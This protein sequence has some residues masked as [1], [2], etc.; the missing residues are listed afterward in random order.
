MTAV[1]GLACELT[2]PTGLS[3]E[4]LEALSGAM[5]R[6]EKTVD[7]LEDTDIDF[8]YVPALAPVVSDMIVQARTEAAP[9]AHVLDVNEELAHA[10]TK[11]TGIS[12]GIVANVL[13]AVRAHH[14]AAAAADRAVT[15]AALL[16]DL[17]SDTDDDDDGP[18]T[19]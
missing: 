13:F 16:A 6:Y 18:D 3:L 2:I 1:V 15:V 17:S 11:S 10:V 8:G 12:Y 14:T 19:T 9:P 5:R 4:Q 7:S